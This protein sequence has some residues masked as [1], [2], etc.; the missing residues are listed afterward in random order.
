VKITEA[1]LVHN[2]ERSLVDNDIKLFLKRSFLKMAY[3]RGG[4]DGWQADEDVKC[5]CRRAAGLF[6]YAVAIAKFLDHKN[7][8]PR[9]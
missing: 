5:L 4:L 9:G 3:R 2:V 6:V 1:F 7:N 8:D